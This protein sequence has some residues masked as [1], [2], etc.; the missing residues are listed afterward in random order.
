MGNNMDL[1]TISFDIDSELLAEAELIFKKYGLT[2]EEAIVLFIKA[3]IANGD[4][5]FTY[6]KEDL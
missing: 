5:P 2:T 6:L 4:I 1:I 3:T